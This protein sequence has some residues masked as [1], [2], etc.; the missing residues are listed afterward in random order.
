M[1]GNVPISGVDTGILLEAGTNELE[2][3]VLQVGDALYGVNVAKV[4]EV[5]PVPNINALPESHPAVEGMTEIRGQVVQLVNLKQFLDGGCE[6]SRP[7]PT[8]KMMIMEFNED[9]IG[10]RVHGVDQ[11][12]R[13]SW[14]QV[15]GVPHIA[16]I[17]A[18]VTAVA[19]IGDKMVLMLD[20]EAI[21]AAVGMSRD[22]L[23]AQRDDLAGFTRQGD[24]LIVFADDSRMIRQMLAETLTD[25]GFTNIRGFSDGAEA[26]D[27]LSSVAT[28]DSPEAT[29]RKV[30]ALISD[31]EMPQMDG[32]NLTRRVRANAALSDLPIILFSSIVSKDNNKKGEQ[33]GASAQVAKPRYAELVHT[34]HG[35][36]QPAAVV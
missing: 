32:L 11:I 8:D 31:V 30:A 16:G 6:D 9:F 36:L 29:R 2:I 34:L 20:F 26:W 5:L 10:F 7:R 4:R 12:W 22:T 25:A 27:Y 21:G 33:V 23:Q 35:F 24:E 15:R 3:L 13:N 18:P 28:E 14:D 17:D 1:A 19:P